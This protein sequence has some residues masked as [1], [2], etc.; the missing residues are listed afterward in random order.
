M[1]SIVIYIFL[2]FLALIGIRLLAN[3]RILFGTLWIFLALTG[4]LLTASPVIANNLANLLGVGR[5]ADLIFYVFV[6]FA[7][8]AILLLTGRL[9][10]IEKQLL[11]LV[12]W[13]ALEKAAEDD[14]ERSGRK[15][16]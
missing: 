2:V 5:G 6:C 16:I 13:S 3:G 8:G 15:K 7:T 1:I 9:R 11:N 10:T 14:H 4:S 12:R